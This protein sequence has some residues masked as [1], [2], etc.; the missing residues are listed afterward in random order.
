[1]W[2]AAAAQRPGSGWEIDALAQVAVARLLRLPEH[3]QTHDTA[4]DAMDAAITRLSQQYAKPLRVADLAAACGCSEGHFHRAFRTRTGTT[5]VAFVTAERMRQAMRLI[6]ASNLPLSAIAA[7]VGY[8]DP[9]YFSRV[10][11]RFAQ[12]TP[13]SYRHNVTV[14]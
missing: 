11:K 4:A 6:T 5:P 9:L 1:M 8:A 14:D 2:F 10:F 13:Q 3:L 12:C 7:A